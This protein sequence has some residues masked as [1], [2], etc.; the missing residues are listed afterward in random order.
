MF[1]VLSMLENAAKQKKQSSAA[2]TKSTPATSISTTAASSTSVATS[3]E[4]LNVFGPKTPAKTA[5]T[6]V[7]APSTSSKS[8]VS[9]SNADK[10]ASKKTSPVGEQ[11]V[12]PSA[13]PAK[14]T[15]RRLKPG[16]TSTVYL[17]SFIFVCSR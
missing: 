6:A 1:E 13:V 11:H 10:G 14:P 3:A 9:P 15:S 12:K 8:S 2:K 16:K 4:Y 7:A 5:A 17:F